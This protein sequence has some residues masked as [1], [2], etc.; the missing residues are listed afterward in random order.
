MGIDELLA[1]GPDVGAGD[2]QVTQALRPSGK[3]R[4]KRHAPSAPNAPNELV[5][6]VQVQQFP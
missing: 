1:P 2:G 6:G 3:E 5:G 4:A